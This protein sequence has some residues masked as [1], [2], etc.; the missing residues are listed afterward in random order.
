VRNQENALGLQFLD[1]LWVRSRGH[2]PP[3]FVFCYLCDDLEGKL[4]EL[5]R[6][7][8]TPSEETMKEEE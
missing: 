6:I 2:E 3:T 4:M 7:S 1:L 8:R 5:I